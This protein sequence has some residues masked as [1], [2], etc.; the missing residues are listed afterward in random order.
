MRKINIANCEIVCGGRSGK[1]ICVIIDGKHVWLMTRI[2]V[3]LIRNPDR[4]IHIVNI[5][6]YNWLGI[7][8]KEGKFTRF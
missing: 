1:T 3:S 7:Y 8:T 2:Y 5:N 6:G 4:D